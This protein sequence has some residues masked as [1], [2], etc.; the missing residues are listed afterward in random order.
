MKHWLVGLFK[1]GKKKKNS[2]F[3]KPMTKILVIETVVEIKT[4]KQTFSFSVR[5]GTGSFKD[6]EYQFFSLS[7]SPSLPPLQKA[8][9]LRKKPK[10][11]D[12]EK[13]GTRRKLR[14]RN[15]GRE[16]TNYRE[17]I[18]FCTNS[19]ILSTKP[20]HTHIIHPYTARGLTY[21]PHCA[22]H[23]LVMRHRRL[24]TH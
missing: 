1:G 15:M 16:W 6:K 18:R 7:I 11:T 13:E 4:T 8:I 5:N 20:T 19:L 24:Y 3:K 21:S 17:W 12:T 14:E 22:T 2:K 10:E 9:C 23:P